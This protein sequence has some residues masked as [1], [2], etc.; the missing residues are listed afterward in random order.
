MV[1]L[2]AFSEAQPASAVPSKPRYLPKRKDGMGPP[3]NLYRN[4]R[5]GCTCNK[6]KLETNQMSINRL[7]DQQIVGCP[8]SGMKGT[9]H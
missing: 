1:Q 9:N 2:A 4:A 5:S 7:V 8:D 3:T 6:K